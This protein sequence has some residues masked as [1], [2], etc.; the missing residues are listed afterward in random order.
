MIVPVTAISNLVLTK[1][2]YSEEGNG[3]HAHNRDRVP[4]IRPGIGHGQTYLKI[5]KCLPLETYLKSKYMK[6]LLIFL[7][8][9]ICSLRHLQFLKSCK[10]LKSCNLT[11]STVK[12]LCFS[13]SSV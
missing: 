1:Q 3:A 9:R 10:F 8:K 11:T 12:S 2:I 13:L 4:L 6:R 7:N 5:L